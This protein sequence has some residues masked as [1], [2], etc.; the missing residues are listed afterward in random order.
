MTREEKRQRRRQNLLMALCWL[1][2]L[3]GVA[4]LL[5]TCA[6]AACAAE[7]VEP[8]IDPLTEALATIGACWVAWALMRGIEWLDK[9]RKKVRG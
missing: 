8:E 6:S 4:C 7:T 9:P 3:A 2:V 5:C 1:I